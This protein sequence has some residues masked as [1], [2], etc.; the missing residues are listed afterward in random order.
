MIALVTA[1]STQEPA[2]PILSLSSP[3]SG[4]VAKLVAQLFSNDGWDVKYVHGPHADIPK[5]KCSILPVTTGDDLLKVLQS[6]APGC[7]AIFLGMT[8]T[9]IRRDPSASDATMFPDM[10]ETVPDP[11]SHIR[12]L[13]GDSSVI[14]GKTLVTNSCSTMNMVDAARRPR[15]SNNW[16]FA[17]SEKVDQT[18]RV[19]VTRSESFDVSGPEDAANMIF[20]RCLGHL[21][22]TRP[23]VW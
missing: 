18:E 4:W 2:S 22:E 19:F 5:G 21:E 7:D 20:R 11:G 9:P 1:G 23:L 16:N 10:M 12:A 14:V 17:I 13:V 6:A 8:V 15:R 3:D